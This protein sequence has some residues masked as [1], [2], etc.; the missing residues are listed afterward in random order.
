MGKCTGGVRHF[1]LTSGV[2]AGTDPYTGR[3]RALWRIYS[4]DFAPIVSDFM[5]SRNSSREDTPTFS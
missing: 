3:M 1:P 4:V 2:R 5:R